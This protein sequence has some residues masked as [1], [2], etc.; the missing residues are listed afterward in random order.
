MP[1]ENN[2]KIKARSDPLQHSN[3]VAKPKS[4]MVYKLHEM[5]I[6]SSYVHIGYMALNNALAKALRP[7]MLSVR[8]HAIL[9]A[10]S[11]TDS[12]LTTMEL[13]RLLLVKSNCVSHIVDRLVKRR[14]VTRRR[15]RVDR[16]LVEIRLTTDGQELIRQT[17]TATTSLMSR[18]FQGHFSPEELSLLIQLLRR[19]SNACDDWS[20]VKMASFDTVEKLRALKTSPILRT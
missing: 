15:S 6:F 18:V 8:E 17:T 14:L 16:R 10:L 13:T 2:R 1:Q 20:G 12:Y 7:A 3:K 11:N 4:P 9:W 5:F 19:I